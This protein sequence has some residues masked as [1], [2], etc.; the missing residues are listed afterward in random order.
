MNGSPGPSM[1]ADGLAYR[2]SEALLAWERAADSVLRAERAL[3]EA[4]F[5]HLKAVNEIGKLLVPENT[6]PGEG[7]SLWVGSRILTVKKLTPYQGGPEYE[8]SWRNGGKA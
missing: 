2:I 6:S 1:S 7:F 5:S 8:L 4:R 3:S